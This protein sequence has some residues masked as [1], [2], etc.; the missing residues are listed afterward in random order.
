M[1][2]TREF[3]EKL[4]KS[5][6]HVHLDG[7]IRLETL[8][9]LARQQNV[10]LPSYTTEGLRELVFKDKYQNLGEY[11]AGFGYTTRVLQNAEALERVAYELAEDYAG[12][13]IRYIEIRFAPQLHVHQNLYMEH[14]LDA[15]NRGL[16]GFASRFNR[17]ER[18][19][20]GAEPAFR[21]GII[22]CAMRMFNAKFSAYYDKFS[23]VHHFSPQKR[24]LR[25]ASEEL[26]MAAVKIRDDMGLPIVGFDLAGQESGY[27]AEDHRSAYHY[28]HRNF[29]KKTVHAGEAYGPESIFQ[30]I[31]DLYADRIGHGF[32]LY[33]TDIIANPAITDKE[34]YVRKLANFIADRR[35]TLEVCLTSNMQTM[36]ELKRLEDHALKKFLEHNLSI[37]LCTDNRT[38]SN[39]SIT[40][41]I[42][43]AVKHFN[44]DL[45]RLKN[46]LIYGFKRS[47]FPGSYT[48]KREYVRQIIDYYEFLERQERERQGTFQAE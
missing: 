33:S 12:E 8:I 31:T 2:I 41:E 22:C 9:D 26:A 7:S 20:S 38:V 46:I 16:S 4:P 27:P 14:V 36:P 25:L 34:A 19:V 30:A 11:L 40:Q 37:S 3:I 39:T 47:F 18:I 1:R 32:H 15:V 43:L 28:A 6:L 44:V 23:S 45:K 13:G 29:L 10:E 42:E 17:Q 24:V 35:I 48:E 21:F 5:D